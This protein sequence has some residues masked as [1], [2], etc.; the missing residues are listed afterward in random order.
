MSDNHKQKIKTNKKANLIIQLR[1][2]KQCRQKS[3]DKTLNSLKLNKKGVYYAMSLNYDLNK[4]YLVWR[5]AFM[6]QI[7]WLHTK[8]LNR[9]KDMRSYRFFFW[10]WLTFTSFLKITFWNVWRS[11][12]SFYSSHV[13]N[14]SCRKR[15]QV[16]SSFANELLKP[17]TRCDSC[18]ACLVI[19]NVAF[20]IFIL[21]MIG[22]NHGTDYFLALFF[23]LNTKVNARLSICMRFNR[24][25]CGSPL[26]VPSRCV[27][28]LLL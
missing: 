23:W 10:C 20:N 28:S 4:R 18:D 25:C 15:T 13:L 17:V 11:S 22:M 8:L 16:G 24:S 9:N 6:C 7:I 19:Y 1:K 27:P 3:I 26:T 21:I 2:I 12:K 5:Q 14:D